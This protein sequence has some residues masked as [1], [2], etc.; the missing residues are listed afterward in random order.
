MRGCPPGLEVASTQPT[1]HRH[2]QRTGHHRR[3]RNALVPVRKRTRDEFNHVCGARRGETKIHTTTAA[4]VVE[5][6]VKV[7]VGVS[8]IFDTR[9]LF[10]RHPRN[11]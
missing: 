3:Q 1:H 5:G 6:T 10:N 4:R 2:S 9:F 7:A 8:S 11:P